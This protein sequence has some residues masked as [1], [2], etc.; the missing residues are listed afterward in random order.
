[1][2]RY[3]CSCKALYSDRKIAW[4]KNCK[5]KGHELYEVPEFIYRYIYDL[6]EENAL[7]RDKIRKRNKYIATLKNRILNLN[8]E[9]DMLRS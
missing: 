1:M 7:L 9:L 6:K 2:I 8:I 5:L 3:I 4:E